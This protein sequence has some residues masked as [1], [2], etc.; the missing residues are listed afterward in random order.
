M[1]AMVNAFDP[2]SRGDLP[3]EEAA[4]IERRERLLGPAYRLFYEHPVHIVSGEGVWLFDKAGRRYLDV[5]NNVPVVG[6]CHPR[7]VEALARQAAMLN[8]HTRYLHESVLDLAE[9]LLATFPR[10]LSQVMFTC[11]GSEANDLAI[12]VA[13]AYTKGSG[14]IVTRTPITASP[15]RSRVCRPRSARRRARRQCGHRGGADRAR[16]A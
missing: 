16:A 10:Q 4:L 11:T 13:K 1:S 5:Y 12:R 2:Q 3:A 14:F 15:M 8:T 7:V 9:A 6:H